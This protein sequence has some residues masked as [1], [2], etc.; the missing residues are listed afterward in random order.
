[1]LALGSLGAADPSVIVAVMVAAEHYR[2]DQALVS[3]ACVRR[4]SV[5]TDEAG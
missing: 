4:H 1:M 3:F 5:R 2:V